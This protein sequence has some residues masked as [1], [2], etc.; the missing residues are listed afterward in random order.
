MFQRNVREVLE[1]EDKSEWITAIDK[2]I[3]TLVLKETWTPNDKLPGIKYIKTKL[4]LVNKYN[5]TGEIARRKARLVVRGDLE[6][7][8]PTENN[9]AL[10]VEKT[11]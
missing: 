1:G 8:S 11:T 9:Y 3:Q 4:H 7:Y 10:A 2:E 6:K 5:E